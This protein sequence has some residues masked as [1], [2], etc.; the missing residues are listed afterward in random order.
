MSNYWP[1]AA[2]QLKRRLILFGIEKKDF[3]AK[4]F[5]HLSFLSIMT[6]NR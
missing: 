1:Y 3:P 5:H 6:E 4:S 2:S